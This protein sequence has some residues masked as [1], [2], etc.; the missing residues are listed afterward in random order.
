MTNNYIFPDVLGKAMAKI[1]IR[2][3]LEASMMSM[4]LMMIGLIITAIYVGFYVN[5]PLWYKIVLEINFLAGIVFMWSFL[6]QN[7]QSY[8]NVLEVIN[9]RKKNNERR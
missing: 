1:D 6:I 4:T 2:T 3:Q 7:F 8:Q 5:F 9:F